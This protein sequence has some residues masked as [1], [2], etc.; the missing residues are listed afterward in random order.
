MS[1]IIPTT[2]VDNFF[3]D[4]AAVRKFALSLDYKTDPEGLWP[5][6]RS[7][8][9]HTVNRGFFD[10]FSGKFLSL[11]YDIENDERIRWIMDVS[12]QMI[13]SSYGEGWVHSDSSL[14]SGVVYLNNDFDSDAGT[15]IYKAKTLGVKPIHSDKKIEEVLKQKDNSSYRKENNDQFE[16]SIVI[17]NKF[18]RLVAFDGSSYH[19]GNTFKGSTKDDSRLTLVFFVREL[20]GDRYPIQRLRTVAIE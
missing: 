11:F 7:E 1:Y 6:K 15:T 4:P 5:G 18:N 13:D 8:R 14:I 12:F 3:D 19:A 20:T 9:L 10:N 16:E 2:V 17:K